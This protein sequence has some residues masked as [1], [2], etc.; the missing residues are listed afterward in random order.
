[1]Y[2]TLMQAIQHAS[3]PDCDV[4]E[5]AGNVVANSFELGHLKGEETCLLVIAYLL[6]RLHGVPLNEQVRATS[7]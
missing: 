3:N 5:M 1:M 2:T 4:S 7:E 6:D